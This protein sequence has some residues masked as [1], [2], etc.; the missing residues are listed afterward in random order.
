V[1]YF[2]TFDAIKLY[3]VHLVH[4]IFSF[5]YRFYLHWKVECK[6]TDFNRAKRFVN[7]K[8]RNKDILCRNAYNYQHSV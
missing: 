3:F 2:V 5:V 7:I 1:G 4:S 8:Y 6:T